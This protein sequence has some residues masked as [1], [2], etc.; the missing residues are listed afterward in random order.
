MAISGERNIDAFISIDTLSANTRYF[1]HNRIYIEIGFN[2]P[3]ISNA[4]LKDIR[5]YV[6]GTIYI[7]QLVDIKK[8]N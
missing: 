1:N 5:R 2:H 8:E 3:S 6:L 7:W 4:V